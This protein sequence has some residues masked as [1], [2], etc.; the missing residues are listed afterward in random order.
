MCA[1]EDDW[2]LA[3]DGDDIGRRLE[4]HIVNEDAESLVRFATAFH[5][6]VESLM[7]R[8]SAHAAVGVLLYGGDSILLTVPESQVDY[9]VEL[10][11]NMTGA[12]DFTFSGGYGRTMR[13]AYFALKMA[14][15]TGK[16]RV[17]SF[18]PVEYR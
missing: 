3:L 10:V 12:T 1:V 8:I 2:F 14:K 13:E 18:G 16:N 17:V 7:R 4:F 6:L 9:I 11:G 5:E 15:A